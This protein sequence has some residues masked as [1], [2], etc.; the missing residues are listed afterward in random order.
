MMFK[1]SD[2]PPPHPVFGCSAS[3]FRHP[4]AKSRTV[5]ADTSTCPLNSKGSAI[6]F[7]CSYQQCQA[8][9]YRF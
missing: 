6:N 4:L 8:I 3:T 5:F 1:A 9:R 7:H 2:G